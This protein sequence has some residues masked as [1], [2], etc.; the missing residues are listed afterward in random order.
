MRVT[1]VSA[2]PRF[3]ALLV[4][5]AVIS[6]LAGCAPAGDA[7]PV[8]NAWTA[9]GPFKKSAEFAD[10]PELPGP[11]VLELPDGNRATLDAD[12]LLGSGL[13]LP[14]RED[15][16]V[17]DESYLYTQD[18]DGVDGPKGPLIVGLV[19]TKHL[20]HFRGYTEYEY[21]TF[22]LGISAEDEPRELT[23]TRIVRN[24]EHTARFA[25][26]S[27][28][29]VVAVELQGD[30]SPSEIDAH[31]TV[32]VDAVRG[33][34][35]WTK[36]EG[37]PVFGEHTAELLLAASADACA[38]EVQRYNVANGNVVASDKLDNTDPAKG[39]TCRVPAEVTSN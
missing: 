36:E 35:V 26:R 18:A 7:L 32:G 22:V 30:L 8:P 33:T 19:R 14:T 2:R 12:R 4:V 29:G 20:V 28:L 37:F 6:A 16:E 15:Y 38:S 9:F 5:L 17:I 3:R 21:V 10:V 25:G 11:A 23:R 24:G 27:D 1:S 31:K 13:R 39:G 34:S